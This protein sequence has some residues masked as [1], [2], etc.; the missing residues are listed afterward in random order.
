[1]PCRRPKLQFSL[2]SKSGLGPALHTRILAR[3]LQGTKI[4]V[5]SLFLKSDLEPSLHARILVP[6]LQSAGDRNYSLPFIF[7]KWF[8]TC[9]PCKDPSPLLSAGDRNYSLQIIFEK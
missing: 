2:F 9:S 8:G 6:T 1:M 3:A 4:T 5:Y 7:E